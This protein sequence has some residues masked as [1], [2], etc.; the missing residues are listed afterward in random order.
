MA[1]ALL[2]ISVIAQQAS[3]TITIRL[4]GVKE[5]CKLFLVRN[6]GWSNQQVADSILLNNGTGVFSGELDMPFKA[7][8]VAAYAGQALEYAG[9]QADVLLCYVEAGK[10][11]VSGSD[12]LHLARIT[13]SPINADFTQYHALVLQPAE[14]A[15]RQA[16]I[17]YRV[18]SA[19]KRV[20]KRF[21]D[22]LM[23]GLQKVHKQ[24]DTLKYHFIQQHPASYFSLEA[25]KE[26]AGSSPDP[27]KMGPM[28]T[29]L[30]P[31]LQQS[32]AGRKF[33]ALLYDQGP[34]GVGG[35]APDFTQNDVDDLPV[36]LSDFKGKYVLLDFWASWCGPCRAE[37]PEV[38]KAYHTYR[39]R[40]FTVLGVS[41][42]QPGKK[43]AWLQAIAKD[44]LPW[45]QVSDLQYWNNAV[46][47][48]YEV[49]SIPQN[50]LIDPK[51]KIIAKNLRGE[52]LHQKLREILP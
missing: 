48:L 50:F 24:Q 33:A 34:L 30:S 47:K 9:K 41:L 29:T 3:Y 12:S 11:L 21:V 10:T 52:A 25:L 35:T 36:K 38:R 44:S 4:T 17:A 49:R 2:P 43:D 31:S 6:W 40:N 16:D 45:T 23:A 26:L 18:A 28:F 8:L 20:D 22:S 1:A 5:S 13:G 27:V 14:V 15:G 39:D 46:A 42:D 51:G 19:A 37:N 32:V 7:H